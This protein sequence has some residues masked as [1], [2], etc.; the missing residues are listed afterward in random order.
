MRRVVVDVRDYI[1]GR[2][3]FEHCRGMTR[4]LWQRDQ[5]FHYRDEA[6]LGALRRRGSHY[7]RKASTIVKEAIGGADTPRW[8]CCGRGEFCIL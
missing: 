1:V 2:G 4:V 3:L 6:N 8:C 5:G 7:V